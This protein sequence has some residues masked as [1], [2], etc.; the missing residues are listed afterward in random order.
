MKDGIR[1]HGTYRLQIDEGGKIVGDSGWQDNQVTNE[2]FLNY[3][4]R[5]IQGVSGSSQIGY[6]GLGTGTIPASNATNLAG[7]VQ[8]RKAITTGVSGS[9]TARLT[10]TFSSTDS[11]VAGNS[12]ISNIGLFAAGTATT[13]GTIF[14]GNTYASSSVAT[15]QNVNVTY[16]INFA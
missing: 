15:N 8:K 12:N 5:A 11:F 2:G 7:E 9:T 16:D 10:A 1:V 6:I 4:V 3:L 14:A 13:S